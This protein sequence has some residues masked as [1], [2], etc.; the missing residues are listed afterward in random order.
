MFAQLIHDKAD[1]MKGPITNVSAARI[2]KF[3]CLSDEMESYESDG[4]I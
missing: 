3:V 2:E 4:N 1:S